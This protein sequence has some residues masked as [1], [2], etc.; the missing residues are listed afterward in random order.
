MVTIGRSPRRW[1]E[2]AAIVGA[3]KKSASG[4]SAWISRSS[5]DATCAAASEWPPSSKKSSVMPTSGDAE[6]LRPDRGEARVDRVARRHGRGVARVPPVA[7]AR[8]AA[9]SIFPFA[10]RGHVRHRDE[11]GRHHEVR[12]AIG[13]ERAELGARRVRAFARHVVRDEA[14]RAAGQLDG[15]R[16]RL[17][18]AGMLG[19]PLLDLGELDAEAADL[20]LLVDAAQVLEVA[21]GQDAREIAGP[22]EAR[23]GLGGEGS[24]EEA[25]GVCAA[26]PR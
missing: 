8:S 20:H 3:W 25:V 22:I 12:Q 10:V 18:D 11:L 26:S 1:S 2:S 21:V 16:E 14:L 19:E 9:R 4:R 15:L 5:R 6:E 17:A 23:A 24:G 13:E 7:R